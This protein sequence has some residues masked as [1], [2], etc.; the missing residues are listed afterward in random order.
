MIGFHLAWN[1]R[2]AD[3]LWTRLGLQFD[4]ASGDYDNNASV[5]DKRFAIGPGLYY[6]F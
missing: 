2:L 3:N 5:T 4:S 1:Y 6:S